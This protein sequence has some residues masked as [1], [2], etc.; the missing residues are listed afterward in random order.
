ML[1]NNSKI[2]KRNFYNFY[3][4]ESQNITCTLNYLLNVHFIPFVDIVGNYFCQIILEF[5]KHVFVFLIF[6]RLSEKKQHRKSKP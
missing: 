4:I 2:D 5:Q 6:M 3:Q 1:R